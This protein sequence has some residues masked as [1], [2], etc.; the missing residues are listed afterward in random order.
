MKTL[1]D[2]LIDKTCYTYE[3][4]EIYYKEVLDEIY[5]PVKLAGM[6]IYASDMKDI[7]PVMFR[8]SVA[9]FCSENFIE[10]EGEYYKKDDY[11]EA[12]QEYENYLEENEV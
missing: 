3:D 8:C 4:I 2:Y 7:D 5:E 10:L 11:E 12:A 1:K 6:T 9:D